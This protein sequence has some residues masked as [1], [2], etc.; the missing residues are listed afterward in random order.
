MCALTAP[1][2]DRHRRAGGEN[3]L[4]LR[5]GHHNPVND[6]LEVGRVSRHGDLFPVAVQIVQPEVHLQKV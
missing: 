2:S 3:D 4:H 6:A 5:D 1:V